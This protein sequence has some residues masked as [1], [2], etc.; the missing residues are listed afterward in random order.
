MLYVFMLL[1]INKYVIEVLVCEPF[2]SYIIV[3]FFIFAK[4]YGYSYFN[5]T[6]ILLEAFEIRSSN[7][8]NLETD[9]C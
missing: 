9:S 7:T 4:F 8:Q 2:S 5:I 1:Q 6:L 3:D